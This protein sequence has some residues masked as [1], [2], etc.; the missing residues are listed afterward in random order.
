M[1][2][3]Y[4]RNILILIA[5]FGFLTF[6]LTGQKSD[7]Q[8]K[9]AVKKTPTPAKQKSTP[10]PTPATTKQ[11]TTPTP[12]LATK[13]T[14]KTPP[15][16]SVKGNAN[17]TKSKPAQK[18]QVIVK[19]TSAR[20]RQEADLQSETLQYAELG[21]VFAVLDED[22]DWLN[23]EISDDKNGWIS[24]TIVEN[25]SLSDKNKIY[26]S[27]TDKYLD[28]NNLDFITAANVFYFLKK[29]NDEINS[30]E[31]EFKRFR[32]LDTVLRLIPASRMD[33][34]PYKNFTTK[35]AAEIV[36][37]EPAGQW[38]VNAKLLWELHAN[39]KNKP[40]GEEI[41]WRAAQTS[42][43]GECE[44]YINC[45]LYKLRVTDGEYLN[46]YP[47][48]KHSRD[49]LLN[50]TNFLEPI[51]QDAGQKSVYTGPYD[52]SDR[53]E[54]NKSLAELRTIVSKTPYVEKQKTINQ[55]NHIAEEF[56]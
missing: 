40:I 34:N 19:V 39:N 16:T 35:N 1:I 2:T 21:A 36:Y 23:I 11:K 53:A 25:F 6:A 4:Y 45:Y 37:S 17:A 55:I 33:E 14:T 54:M 9:T 26:Q 13:T 41:A 32:I 42:L 3:N 46:F 7:A 43:P 8:T 28:K 10:K 56:R 47:A 51:N 22:K 5:A 30:G 48:G 20:I 49:A 15:K 24:K 38:F 27:I 50:I 18:K 44:G 29:A 52:I 12:K 31:L